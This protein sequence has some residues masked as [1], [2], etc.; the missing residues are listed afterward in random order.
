MGSP[1]KGNRQLGLRNAEKDKTTAPEVHIGGKFPA[2][3]SIETE[4]HTSLNS[5]LD[6]IFVLHGN[7]M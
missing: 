7:I 2:S 4:T 1:P 6:K 3:K 5:P